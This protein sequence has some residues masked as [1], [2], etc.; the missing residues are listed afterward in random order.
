MS[1]SLP[2]YQRNM[3]KIPVWYFEELLICKAGKH[4]LAEQELYTP[5]KTASTQITYNIGRLTITNA[6]Y[7]FKGKHIYM[8]IAIANQLIKIQKMEMYVIEHP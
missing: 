4:S 3:D 1:L 2:D 6:Y 5:V 8:K 7:P